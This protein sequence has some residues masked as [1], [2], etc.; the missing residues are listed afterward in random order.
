MSLLVL[1]KKNS[2]LRNKGI[3]RL[4]VCPIR[5]KPDDTAEM[6]SQ[7][8]F[9][10]VVEILDTYRSN[11]ILVKC[12]HDGYEGW[13]DTKQIEPISEEI[14]DGS[15]SDYLCLDISE[16]I[17]CDGDST[18]ITLGAVL[19]YFDGMTAKVNQKKYRFSGQVISPP[20]IIPSYLYIEKLARKLMN[21][22]YL[23]GGRSPFG[24]DCSGFTQLIY[25]CIGIALLRDSK[26]Q[27]TQGDI[28]H[29]VSQVMPGDLAFFSKS[30]EHITHVGIIM[31]SNKIVHASGRVR[32][33][34]IDH[35]GIFNNE[36]QEYTHRLKI[37][38]RLIP[39]PIVQG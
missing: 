26:D 24:I 15:Y 1:L 11:W 6:V 4:S 16:P 13:M 20:T 33:D 30:T 29:F 28:V 12:M 21:A 7:L 25:K 19:P 36:I 38:K 39:A 14:I 22:P 2:T 23:W 31:D 17:F 35:Y 3:S 5:S 32:V 27:A 10:E 37:I 8:L 34:T 9:G 18:Y